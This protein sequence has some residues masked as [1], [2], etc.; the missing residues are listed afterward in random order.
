MRKLDVQLDL[1]VVQELFGNRRILRITEAFTDH[2][3]L[4]LEIIDPRLNS[5]DEQVPPERRCNSQAEVQ[6]TQNVSPREDVNIALSVVRGWF[7]GRHSLTLLG[8]FLDE[9]GKLVLELGGIGPEL[10]DFGEPPLRKCKT[11][12]QLKEI[13]NGGPREDTFHNTVSGQCQKRSPGQD[14]A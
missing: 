13:A 9:E 11:L 3:N 2:G 6:E 5:P 4:V 1:S 10:S 7:N 8:A 14:V 12:A